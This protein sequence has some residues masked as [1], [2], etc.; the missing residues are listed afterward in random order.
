MTF[1]SGC[2]TE[3]ALE[4]LGPTVEEAFESLLDVVL[5][6]FSSGG[7]TGGALFILGFK[8]L[9]VLPVP[10]VLFGLMLRVLLSRAH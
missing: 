1:L 9:P 10:G 6:V 4:V 5:S 2:S 3:G 8:L 7:R